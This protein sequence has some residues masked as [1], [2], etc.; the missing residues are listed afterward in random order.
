MDEIADIENSGIEP[1]LAA[2]VH[3][4]KDVRQRAAVSLGQLADPS[5]AP[6]IAGLL[7]QE[8]D[9]FVRETLTWLLTRTP[10]PAAK[11]AA[12]ALNEADAS[13]RVQ[14]LHLLSKLADPDSVATV[15]RHIDDADPLIA[16]KARWA[17][18]RIG[19]PSVIPLLVD[20]LGEAELSTR[21]AM[22]NT[23]MQFGAAAVPTVV[24][25]LSAEDPSVRAHA[26]DVLCYV[27]TPGAQLAIPSLIEGLDD[28]HPDV[29]LAVALAL[30]ELAVY[31][32]ARSALRT[33]SLDSRDARVR[34]VASASL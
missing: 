17:L 5:L 24:S 9:F 23:L 34:S 4:D 13:T 16:D 8:S 1:A 10:E 2:L 18:A 28:G 14:A 33:A 30:R 15:T 25:A 12:A 20:Q 26:A 29:R 32:A 31:P 6:Q 19:D 3:P 11:A 7:W 27:G 21:D 22:T